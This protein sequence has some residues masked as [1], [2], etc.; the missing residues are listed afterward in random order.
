MNYSLQEGFEKETLEADKNQDLGSYSKAALFLLTIKRER[1]N[2][3]R[4]DVESI[5]ENEYKKMQFVVKKVQKFMR[6]TNTT[7]IV[8]Y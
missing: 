5:L 8:I 6:R 4:T 7:S 3:D 2:T 1:E